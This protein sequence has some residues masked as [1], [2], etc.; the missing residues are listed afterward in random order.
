MDPR[1]SWDEEP[2]VD[3]IKICCIHVWN[4]QRIPK[5]FKMGKMQTWIKYIIRV[6]KQHLNI[7]NGT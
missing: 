2:G 4:F 1:E 6:L 5:L 7:T 3:K